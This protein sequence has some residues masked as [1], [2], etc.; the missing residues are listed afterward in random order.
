M[1]ANEKIVLNHVR[2]SIITVSRNASSTIDDCVASIRHQEVPV[3]HIVIDGA[4]QDDTVRK[5][6]RSGGSI[7]HVVSEPDHGMYD[8][9]NKGLALA[10]G[11]VVG[12]LNADD[13]Y[14]HP[15]V[16]SQ[17]ARVFSDSTVDACYGDVVYIDSSGS[18]GVVRAWKSCDYERS[19]FYRGWMPPHPS[20]FVRRRI[21]TK[22][23]GFDLRLGT[24][25]DY[26]LM[27]RLL[28]RHGCA[29]KYIPDT[30]VAMRM[31]GASNASLQNRI[32]ANRMDRLAWSV[33]GLRPRPWTL[34]L[35]PASKIGQY[36]VPR[37][38]DKKVTR[39]WLGN[40]HPDAV[41]E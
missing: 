21:Y 19:L 39:W 1:T 26:E 30:L 41:R 23:G 14:A 38:S 9:M 27:L 24:S 25:A 4:S 33:N 31:G 7:A 29:A 34:L 22:Y 10:T 2:L 35:K 16:L 6:E 11:E 36:V 12:I 15:H 20:F 18:G 3:E 13:F 32:K 37:F 17:V 28:V 8:A 40:S 5:I